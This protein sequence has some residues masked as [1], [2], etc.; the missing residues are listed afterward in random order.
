[1]ADVKELKA[2]EVAGLRRSCV[3]PVRTFRIDEGRVKILQKFDKVVTNSLRVVARLQTIS[4]LPT[5]C[6]QIRKIM[7]GESDLIPRLRN[8]NPRWV[9]ET[10][11]H[12]KMNRAEEAS[13]ADLPAGSSRP[14]SP[15]ELDIP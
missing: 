5:D 12:G 11:E 6:S 1:M 10:R 7:R 8:C 3:S 13:M 15:T 2:G 4:D 9:G 14:M